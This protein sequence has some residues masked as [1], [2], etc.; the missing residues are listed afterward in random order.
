[1]ADDLID[2]YKERFDRTDAKLDRIME[3]LETVT[4]RLGSLE[5]QTSLHRRE[6][7]LLREDFVRLEHRMDGI[8]Q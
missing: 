7:N 8:D 1:V 4:M 5:E 2:F 6:T 3:T